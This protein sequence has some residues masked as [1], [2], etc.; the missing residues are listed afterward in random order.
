METDKLQNNYLMNVIQK[1][2]KKLGK[3]S[4]IITDV[5]KDKS[6]AI[7]TMLNVITPRMLKKFIIDLD[8]VYKLIDKGHVTIHLTTEQSE[9]YGFSNT[10]ITDK[11]F[12]GL[13]KAWNENVI[14]SVGILY[15]SKGKFTDQINIEFVI[16]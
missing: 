2:S 13:E 5:D 16:K 15:E 11:A 3:I 1:R 9:Y 10:V 6:D 14:I 8:I 4:E 7:N 12:K